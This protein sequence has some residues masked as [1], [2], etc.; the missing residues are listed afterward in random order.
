MPYSDSAVIR[1]PK[2]ALVDEI[3]AQFA[4]LAPP[5]HAQAV[6]R[7]GDETRK[8]LSHAELGSD[9]F[10]GFI[11]G[12]PVV[13]DS[14]PDRLFLDGRPARPRYHPKRRS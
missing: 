8:A 7:I 3:Y 13:S 9:Y 1:A 14:D 12:L 5:L 10:V 2:T 11:L 6:W 4:A